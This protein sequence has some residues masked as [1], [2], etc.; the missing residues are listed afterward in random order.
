MKHYKR[1]LSF[2]LALTLALTTLQSIAFAAGSNIEVASVSTIK[3]S[4]TCGADSNNLTWTLDSEGTL[5]ITGS[6]QM[7]DFE[8]MQSPWIDNIQLIRK[9]VISEN[10]TSIGEFAFWGCDNLASIVIA[11]SVTT[12][13]RA[14]FAECNAL[15]S[16]N[17]PNN[18]VSIGSDAFAPCAGLI[19]ITIPNSVITIGQGA[20]TGCSSLKNISLSSNLDKIEGYMFSGCSSL[21]SITIPVGVKEIGNKAFNA[22]SMDSITIPYT[23]TK[24][25]SSAFAYFTVS[26][27]HFMGDAPEFGKEAFD[28][29]TATVCY[30]VNNATYTVENMLNYGGKLTWI[31]AD[32]VFY[33]YNLYISDLVNNYKFMVYPSTMTDAEIRAD[34]AVGAQALIAVIPDQKVI[35]E[36]D[37]TLT[38]HTSFNIAQGNYKSVLTGTDTDGNSLV[39]AILAIAINQDGGLD[40]GGLSQYGDMDGDGKFSVWDATLAYAALTGAKTLDDYSKS[41]AD[42]DNDG[43]LT[44]WEVTQIYNKV[45]NE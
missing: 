8:F 3:A 27:V 23:V 29:V 19:S 30:P 4:G 11:D 26:A 21:E 42:L 22:C 36:E 40:A 43:E 33:R 34:L 44:V 15:T 16:I 1:A 14:A 31:E 35:F 9:I 45:I 12:I 37:G 5:T 25:D 6:G 39:P 13:G 32:P 41:C 17:L 7:S 18:L 24:I 10:V 28:G 2:V 38:Q 20:F